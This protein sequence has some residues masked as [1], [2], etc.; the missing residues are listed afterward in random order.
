MDDPAGLS[1]TALLAGWTGQWFKDE[2][3][4]A[5]AAQ[6]LLDVCRLRRICQARI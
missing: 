6:D 4:Y 5:G 1:V 3:N 2:I